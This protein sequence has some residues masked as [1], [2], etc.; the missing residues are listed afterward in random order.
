MVTVKN[1][2]DTLQETS[3]RRTPNDIYKPLLLPYKSINQVN[4]DQIESQIET[5]LAGSSS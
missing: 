4:T 5:F 2:F 1:K 3:E